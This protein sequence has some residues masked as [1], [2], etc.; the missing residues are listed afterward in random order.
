M[1]LNNIT[2][3][4]NIGRNRRLFAIGNGP[5]LT[6]SQLE[7]IRGEDSIA[8]NRISLIY[9]QTKWRPRYYVFCSTNCEDPRWGT[10]WCS[11][12]MSASQCAET[13]PIIWNRFRDSIEART[14]ETFPTE[15][16]W[17]SSLSENEI[18]DPRTFSTDAEERI[19]KAGT[20]MNVCLQ[21]A[22]WMGYR[23]VILLGCDSNWVS[24][25]NTMAN[26]DPNHFTPNYHAFIA[27][28][29]E[30]FRRMNETHKIARAAFEKAG[31][32]IVNATPG[33]GLTA[34]DK[35]PLDEIL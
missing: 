15:T 30:E 27:D 18:G 8:M 5:S 11:S 14:A 9:D 33:S 26:G 32:R 28:G 1:A 13:R 34:Y 3:L 4:Q 10:A 21:L 16:T 23:E 35:I 17:L 29:A 20:T 22:Y 2:H 24:A 12:I 31:K 7:K 25:K 6:G 19:D